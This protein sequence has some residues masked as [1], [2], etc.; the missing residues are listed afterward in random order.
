MTDLISLLSKE[1][2]RVFSSTTVPK[3]QFFGAQ[4]FYCPALTSIWDCWKKHLI[5]TLQVFILTYALKFF[6]V[7]EYHWTISIYCH[8]WVLFIQGYQLYLFWICPG[9]IFFGSL[10][11]YQSV[12][13]I[14]LIILVVFWLYLHFGL[15]SQSDSPV[16]FEQSL[17]PFHVFCGAS[18]SEDLLFISFWVLEV[19]VYIYASNV[20]LI[21]LCV[22]FSAYFKLAFS[23]VWPISCI[24]SKVIFS[25]YPFLIFHFAFLFLIFFFKL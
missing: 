4:L 16:T 18:F 21:F 11:L 9:Q 22:C 15:F 10:D 1:L 8:H 19:L 25:C 3:H 13:S 7:L 12:I 20:F 5:Y 6:T 17:F 24:L 14:Y 23:T 2:S